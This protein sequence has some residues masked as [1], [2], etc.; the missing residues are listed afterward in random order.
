[1][2]VAKQELERLVQQALRRAG[3]NEPALL[4][5]SQSVIACEADGAKSHGLLRMPAFVHSLTIGWAIGSALPET[6]RETES[7]I[8]VD[9]H[10]GFA[11]HALAV[12]SQALVA[13]ARKTGVAMLLTRNSH[14]FSALWPDI[15]PFAE[16]GLVALTCVN[17]KKRMTAWGGGKA[18]LGTSAMAF[19]SPRLGHRPLVWDQSSSMMS[20]GDVLLAAQEGRSVPEGVGRDASGRPSTSPKDI[21]SGGALSPFGG[22]KGASLAVMV[23]I[24]SAALSG[25]PFGFE[26][27][28]PSEAATTSLGSQF[29]LLIDPRACVDDFYG[30]IESLIA[31]ILEAGTE[32]LPGDRRY[33]T[34][35]QSQTAGVQ[36][37]R[38]AFQIL[39]ALAGESKAP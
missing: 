28:S 14:H 4:A 5:V 37:D 29:L 2:L 12:T 21:L 22:H 18:V 33:A 15:E 32:K 7:L 36:V 19:A 20:Q 16:A 9:A 13:K 25:G 10:Q 1:M 26:D 17:S 34:R 23:E 30:R 3:L 39:L 8:A 38:S 6:R 24:L 27:K 35:A 31:A 11:Q